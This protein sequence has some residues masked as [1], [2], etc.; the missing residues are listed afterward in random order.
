MVRLFS[1]LAVS[2]LMCFPAFADGVFDLLDLQ[3][4]GL[5]KVRECR[6]REDYMDAAEALLEYYRGRTGVCTPE[7][8]NSARINI[9][10]R[11]KKIAD[12]ALDHRFFVSDGY[13]V[14]FYGDDINWRYW[15]LPE[16][17]LRWQLHRHKWFTPMGKAYRTT[18]DDKYA[19]EWKRQYLDWISKN[20][21]VD[22]DA[23]E[24]EI[25]DNMG[26][27]E[28]Q[29]NM[30]FAWR[31]LEVSHRIQD[32]IFQFQLF[33]DAEAFTP[34]FQVAFLGNYHRHVD[35]LSHH[36]S[37]KGNHLLFEAQRML[38]A[39]AFFPEFRDAAQWR[40]TGVEILVREIRSQVYPDGGQWEL[41]PHYHLAS[42][43]IF[44]K[45]LRMADLCGFRGEFP[46]DFTDKLEKM[47][48]FYGEICYP[49]YTNPC[50]SDARIMGK[51]EVVADWKRWSEL[52][53]DN[54]FIRYMATEGREGALP[55]HLSV[56]F[57]DSGFFVFR[58]SR[59]MDAVQMV[60]KAGP[61]G[62]WHCQPDN[63]TF[64]L[65]YKGHR[66]FPDSG[67]YIYA[68]DEQVMAWRNLFRST[69]F[70]NTV[71]LDDKDL[72]VTDSRTI[73]WQPDGKVQKLVT[74]NPSY[75]GLTHRRTIQ[76]ICGR[77]FVIKDELFGDAVG[78][79]ALH[80]HPGPGAGQYFHLKVKGPCGMVNREELGWYSEQ[81]KEKQPRP[82]LIWEVDKKGKCPIVFTTYIDL[83]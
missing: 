18:G 62:E 71:T 7:I 13:E 48:V 23:E 52:F 57:K 47:M 2:L 50:F 78:K 44:C 16:N 32:Q 68:G 5:E 12:D 34:E 56:A 37:K 60:V 79:V 4:P 55:G 15:P 43:N 33:V 36:F 73:L 77:R 1:S 17:E 21:Q 35:Y 58:S 65:W 9:S 6:E 29:E 22:L 40:Q 26:L 30:R 27:S 24:F 74:E 49:D 51:K 64:E 67:S 8:P 39:G 3:R 45:A 82:H 31:P 59:S 54:D 38:Y 69:A 81:I 83:N 11:D 53:P 14:Y 80:L 20:P 76:F 61:P 70:H 19:L 42:I 66:L 72:E 25:T 28:A 41:D 10:A 46:Q 63:G 75:S